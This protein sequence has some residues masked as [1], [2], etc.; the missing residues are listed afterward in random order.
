MLSHV[1]PTNSP[2][3][4]D[5]DVAAL[6]NESADFLRDISKSPSPFR[7]QPLEDTHQQH[8]QYVPQHHEYASYEP[9]RVETVAQLADRYQGPYPPEVDYALHWLQPQQQTAH[10]HQT[11]P[12]YA[13]R[14][15]IRSSSNLQHGQGAEA[16]IGQGDA[17]E[18]AHSAQVLA[19]WAE[20][21]ASY[22]HPLDEGDDDGDE[23]A[24][25]VVDGSSEY[26]TDL[27]HY[28]PQT[29][30]ASPQSPRMMAAADDDEEVC[31]Q[32][33]P[34]SDHSLSATSSYV[35]F[36]RTRTLLP[37]TAV[38]EAK[39]L[40]LSRERRENARMQQ[41]AARVEAVQS[42]TAAFVLSNAVKRQPVTQQQKQ[43]RRKRREG[44][45]TRKA[46]RNMEAAYK[47][48][49]IEHS[50][51]AISQRAQQ[52][53]SVEKAGRQDFVIEAIV[54]QSVEKSKQRIE[55]KRKNA[56]HKVKA[57]VQ[58]RA[59]ENRI[60]RREEVYRRVEDALEDQVSNFTQHYRSLRQEL[61]LTREQR[62]MA[63]K[64]LYDQHDEVVQQGF[65]SSV[66]DRLEAAR[67]SNSEGHHLKWQAA[68]N[69]F[70]AEESR[71]SNLR[72]ETELD[73]ELIEMMLEL[74]AEKFTTQAKRERIKAE[75]ELRAMLQA[76]MGTAVEEE[77]DFEAAMLRREEEAGHSGFVDEM[78]EGAGT[79]EMDVELME[80]EAVTFD[81]TERASLLIEKS[82]EKLTSLAASKQALLDQQ[83]DHQAERERKIARRQQLQEK[84]QQ[85]QKERNAMMMEVHGLP[86]KL[87]DLRQEIRVCR[88]AASAAQEQQAQVLKET[89]SDLRDGNMVTFCVEEVMFEVLEAH[90]WVEG[91]AMADDIHKAQMEAAMRK[92]KVEEE[93]AVRAAAEA[94]SDNS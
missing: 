40:L 61:A 16:A 65:V 49:I 51:A 84:L 41:K 76:T 23:Q 34:I 91:A 67:G 55:E 63:L 66:G 85:I 90:L 75:S 54:D 1:E 3:A 72:H 60:I 10:I 57:T 15:G 4:V 46:A 25:L 80:L 12:N 94:T 73:D 79:S 9:P 47:K 50:L 17:G 56:F 88:V 87:D 64:A 82:E 5:S 74:E 29:P 28:R 78:D 52:T 2:Y 21:E 18:L 32:T 35:S 86:W 93:E 39:W 7:Q 62:L 59:E 27:S 45:Y 44:S 36:G 19:W 68:Q 33:A 70:E 26:E 81:L 89:E 53:A 83:R 11:A 48:R 31:S 77:E 69:A 30:D 38:E 92:L 43:E 6:M 42:K 14:E 13:Q 22:A 58:Q 20:Q 37:K 8:D 71:K 24:V